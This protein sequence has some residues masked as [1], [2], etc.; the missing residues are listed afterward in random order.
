MEIVRP[1]QSSEISRQGAILCRPKPVGR[2]TKGGQR[3]LRTAAFEAFMEAET[4]PWVA[5]WFKKVSISVF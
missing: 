1:K 4:L 3:G 2:F 5:R